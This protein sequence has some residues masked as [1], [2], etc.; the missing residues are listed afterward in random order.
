MQSTPRS[1]LMGGMMAEQDRW[2]IALVAL[3][4]TLF[5]LATMLVSGLRYAVPALI[6]AAFLAGIVYAQS[7][8]TDE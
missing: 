5:A 6:T 1:V 2:I 4:W 3:V 8:L 7:H